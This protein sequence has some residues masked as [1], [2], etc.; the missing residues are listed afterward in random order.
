MTAVL[1]QFAH[2][3]NI[4]LKLQL[5]VVP[6]LDL[7]WEIAAEPVRSESEAKYPSVVKYSDSPWGPR[8]RM[9]WFMDHW[10]GTDQGTLVYPMRRL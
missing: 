4:E 10:V 9:K 1:A 5:M 2:K 3:E 8:H 7:R 6:S